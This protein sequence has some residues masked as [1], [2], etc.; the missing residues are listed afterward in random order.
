MCSVCQ[1]E[2]LKAVGQQRAGSGNATYYM[3]LDAGMML[4]PVV[5]GALMDCIGVH[6]FFQALMLVSPV[7]LFVGLW[8]VRRSWSH[9]LGERAA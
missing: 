9:L 1:S 3:G 8:S 7:A 4:G 5:G 2:A 6:G